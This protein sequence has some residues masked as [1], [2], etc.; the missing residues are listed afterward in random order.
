ME[1]RLTVGERF[2]QGFVTLGA[3]ESQFNYK[4]ETKISKTFKSEHNTIV[5]SRIED[6]SV[7]VEERHKKLYVEVL[8]VRDFTITPEEHKA[9]RHKEEFIFTKNVDYMDQDTFEDQAEDIGKSIA[10]IIK[11]DTLSYVTGK[12]LEMEG[13]I[14]EIK[15]PEIEIRGYRK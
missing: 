15:Q 14:L 6:I 12:R 3:L 8:V 5:N 9:N 7:R 2:N 1:K 13:W 4:I 11:M 10:Q